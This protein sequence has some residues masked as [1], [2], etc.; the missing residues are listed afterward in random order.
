MST[1]STQAQAGTPA[2]R[3]GIVV[4]QLAIVAIV[5]C[6]WQYAP[7]SILDDTLTSRPTLIAAQ[8]VKWLGSG[9]LLTEGWFTLSAV[10]MGL[11]AG[12]SAGAL[13]GLVAGAVPALG[14]LI[15]PPVKFLFALP[16]IAF[17]PLFIV[18]FGIGTFQEAAFTSVVVFF[19]FFYSTFNGARAVPAP[20]RDMLVIAG[21]SRGQRLRLLYLP[22]SLSWLLSGLQLAIPYAFVSAVTAEIVSS[23]HGLG[24]LVKTSAS[25]MDPAGMFAAMLSLLLI[26]VSLS[27]LVHGFGSRSRWTV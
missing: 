23:Q 12:G 25:V 10:L 22:A 6:L 16:K 17:V 13:A 15:E 19:F 4:L 14:H 21:S 18:W 5:L 20:L 26:S 27:V 3:A 24:N 2:T 1:T 7:D 8:C 11:A 9:V